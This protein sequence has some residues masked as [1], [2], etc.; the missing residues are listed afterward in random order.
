MKLYIQQIG[1]LYRDPGRGPTP[2]MPLPKPLPTLPEDIWIQMDIQPI[3]TKTI[4]IIWIKCRKF[5][6]KFCTFL[7]VLNK[8]IIL[9]LIFRKEIRIICIFAIF[10]YVFQLI[11]DSQLRKVISLYSLINGHKKYIIFRDTMVHSSQKMSKISWKYLQTA[12]RL[13]KLLY[14]FQRLN[15]TH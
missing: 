9:I 12:D 6:E 4:E 13:F 10:F 8:N 5:R 2:Q 7:Y 14:I 3:Y 15:Y 1:R 11:Q